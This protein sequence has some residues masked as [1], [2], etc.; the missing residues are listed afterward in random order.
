MTRGAS[1]EASRVTSGCDSFALPAADE[2]HRVVDQVG[3]AGL[4]QS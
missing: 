4:D 3:D 2:S 1:D